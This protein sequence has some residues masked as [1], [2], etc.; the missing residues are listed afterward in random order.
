M[1][2][3]RN[4]SNTRRVNA[5]DGTLSPRMARLVRESWWLLVV[6]I[7]AYLALILASYTSTDPGWSFSGTG[8][9]LGNRGGPVGAWVADL[10]L[11]L[12]GVSAWWWVVGGIVLVIAGFRLIVLAEEQADHPLLLGI[13]GFALVRLSSASLESLRLWKLTT[14]LPLAPGG[15]FGDALGQGA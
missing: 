15:A 3:K 2:F 5:G 9:P 7:L 11:Y 13:V 8:A 12:F 10:L 4:V 6:A 1:F 14:T